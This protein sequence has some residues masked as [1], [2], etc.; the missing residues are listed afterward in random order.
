MTTETRDIKAE[1]QHAL[2]EISLFLIETDGYDNDL[3]TFNKRELKPSKM[4]EPKIYIAHICSTREKAWE[5]MMQIR[6]QISLYENYFEQIFD[7]QKGRY[8]YSCGDPKFFVTGAVFQIKEK[9]VTELINDFQLS[10]EILVQ[11]ITATL[12]L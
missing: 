6:Q 3:L 12:K 8:S 7:E 2:S 4:G 9:K 1:I 5:K 10:P 11:I